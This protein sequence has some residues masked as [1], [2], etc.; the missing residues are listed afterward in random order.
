MEDFASS[1]TELRRVDLRTQSRNSIQWKI[2]KNKILHV[3][4]K[5][6]SISLRTKAKTEIENE[7]KTL[8]SKILSCKKCTNRNE[9]KKIKSYI[10]TV[11]GNLV[12]VENSLI[13]D[14]LIKNLT[15]PN[16]SGRDSRN[17]Q[18]HS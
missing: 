12:D 2:I 9:K 16:E 18:E 4:N 17:Q 11:I 3:H 8:I 5:I 7:K 13:V 14:V 15:Q 1:L 6:A 10:R